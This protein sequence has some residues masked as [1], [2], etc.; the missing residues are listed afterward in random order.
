MSITVS[1][2]T[3]EDDT[4]AAVVKT[5]T[6]VSEISTFGFIKKH[7]PRD[8]KSLRKPIIV[9]SAV[10]AYAEYNITERVCNS[11][12]VSTPAI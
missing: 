11:H 8:Y 10:N 3:Q 6:L 12:M 1:L 7:Q 4:I 2:D 9:I 5:T